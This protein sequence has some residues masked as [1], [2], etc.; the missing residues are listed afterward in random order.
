MEPTAAQAATPPT[1]ATPPTTAPTTQSPASSVAPSQPPQPIQPEIIPTNPPKKSMRFLPILIFLIVITGIV[2]A[3]IPYF[4]KSDS[5]CKSN[6]KNCAVSGWRTNPA[7]I[8]SIIAYAGQLQYKTNAPSKTAAKKTTPAPTPTLDPTMDWKIHIN[9]KYSYE[10]KC[11]QTNAY[12]VEVPSGDGQKMP[13]YQE[14]CSEAKNQMRVYVYP[15]THPAIA[16]DG[17]TVKEYPSPT[18]REKVVLRGFDQAYFAKILATFKFIDVKPTTTSAQTTA[19]AQTAATASA[20]TVPVGVPVNWKQQTFSKLGLILYTAPHWQS[21][22]QEFS[23]TKASLIR[24]W[25]GATRDTATIQLEVKDTWEST[26]DAPYL[27]KNYTVAGVPAVKVDPPKKTE[28]TLDR[29]QTN[30]YFE[31]KGKVY[32][33]TCVHNWIPEQYQICDTMLQTLQF[34][35]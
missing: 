12:A 10:F 15:L 29:Y 5:S 24:F 16:T 33:F 19:T 2:F 20:S 30:V 22:I 28:K 32:A 17:A 9:T 25:L 3:P 4:V 13:L 6:Q 7:L 21:S 8:Q 34:T 1:N 35:P 31:T 27:A 23:D 26:G 11:P 14:V 18:S